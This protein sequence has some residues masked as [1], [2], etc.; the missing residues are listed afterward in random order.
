MLLEELQEQGI[1]PKNFNIDMILEA[2]KLVMWWSLF[3]DGDCYFKQLTGTAM[4]WEIQTEV[5][6][7]DQS[8]FQKHIYYQAI[9]AQFEYF[10]LF[11]CIAFI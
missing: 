7:Y 9:F 3:D 6:E 1:L 5:D 10:L 2:T 4:V 11:S 8:Q